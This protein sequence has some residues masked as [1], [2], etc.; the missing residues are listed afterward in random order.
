MSRWARPAS[1]SLRMME[2]V[3]D[4]P[5]VDLRVAEL[6]G[7]GEELG[8][9]Q[10]LAFGGELDHAVGSGGGQAGVAAQP[11]GV[12]LLLDEAPHGVEG[13]FVLEASVE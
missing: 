12:V 2:A 6:G 10:V 11:Q 3:V 13:L 7:A 1:H 5:L 4:H 8:D 9:Q